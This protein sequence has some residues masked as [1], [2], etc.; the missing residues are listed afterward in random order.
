MR[1]HVRRKSIVYQIKIMTTF[2]NIN[3]FQKSLSGLGRILVRPSGTE[4]L[5]RIL[6]ESKDENLIDKYIDKTVKVLLLE[7][8]SCV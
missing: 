1:D 7:N 8:S 6:V 2:D 3:L 4:P 5:I